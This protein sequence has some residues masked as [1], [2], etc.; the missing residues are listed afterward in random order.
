MQNR[1]IS[2]YYTGQPHGYSTDRCPSLL[3]ILLG[4]MWQKMLMQTGII[5]F[6][7]WNHVIMNFQVW[8]KEQNHR[9]MILI[10]KFNILYEYNTLLRL[11]AQL[12][13]SDQHGH[14]TT[15][16]C[17]LQLGELHKAA[18]LIHGC[19]YLLTRGSMYCMVSVGN[20]DWISPSSMCSAC[21]NMADKASASILL[22]LCPLASHKHIMKVWP[23]CM[24]MLQVFE[25][26][27]IYVHVYEYVS[28]ASE[29]TCVCFRVL[30]STACC[31]RLT[32]M[33]TKH[34]LVMSTHTSE[35]TKLT[36]HTYMTL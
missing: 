26:M 2:E 18:A 3:V 6:A 7:N 11:I 22:W 10:T 5:P 12:P 13:T 27:C 9:L 19:L 21:A 36:A 4:N 33:L 20:C 34:A 29:I 25:C 17:S 15:W 24:C 28:V 35:H 23:Y 16:W 8:W 30:S 31:N 1:I 14:S 32:W